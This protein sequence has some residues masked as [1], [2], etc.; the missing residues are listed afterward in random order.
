M[1]CNLIM[2]MLESSSINKIF[3]YELRKVCLQDKK[4]VQQNCI[5]EILKALKRTKTEIP[6]EKFSAFCQTIIRRTVVDYYRKKNRMIDQ[7][8][9]LVNYCDGADDESGSTSDYFSMQIK[10]SGYDYVE[11]KVDYSRNESKFT[12]REKEVLDYMLYDSYGMFMSMSEIARKLQMNK[13]SATRAVQKLRELC[14]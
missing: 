1:K 6:Q 12:K 11:L 14:C 13:S 5:L 9:T 3:N 4:D 8:T 7:V 2:D 10:E